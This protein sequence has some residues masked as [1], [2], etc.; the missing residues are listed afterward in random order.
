M[1]SEANLERLKATKRNDACP[2]GSGRKYKKCHLAED[3]AAMHEA[4]RQASK[5]V[6]GTADEGGSSGKKKEPAPSA[7]DR[8]QGRQK[9]QAKAQGQAARPK[10]LPRRKAV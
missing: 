6:S 10:N 9:T 3:E 2:C 5:T 4:A 7:A 8:S 1:S